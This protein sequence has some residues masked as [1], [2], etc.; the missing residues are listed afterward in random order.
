MDIGLVVFQKTV[1]FMK[2]QYASLVLYL[3]HSGIF[4][5]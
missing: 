5:Y 4:F 1:L 2:S 3:F